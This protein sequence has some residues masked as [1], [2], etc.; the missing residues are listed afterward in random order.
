MCN[1]ARKHNRLLQVICLSLC[2]FA[3]SS[4]AT[5]EEVT[6]VPT[7]HELDSLLKVTTGDTIPVAIPRLISIH[8]NIIDWITTTPNVTVEIDLSRFQ[9]SRFSILLTGKYNP[10]IN[11]NTIQPRWVYNVSSVKVEFRKYWRTGNIEIASIPDTNKIEPDTTLWKPLA[12]LSYFQR[13]YISG[14]YVKYPRYWRA[15]YIGLYAAYNTFS[16]CLDGSGK[17][18]SAFSFGLSAG[19]SVPLYKHHDGSGWDL[20]LGLSVGAMITSYKKYKYVSEYGIFEYENTKPKHLLPYP[21]FQDIHI[22]LAYRFRTIEKKVLYGATRFHYKEYRREILERNRLVK[23]HAKAEREDSIM[24]YTDIYKTLSK[25]HE[26]LALYTDTTSYYYT[27]LNGAIGYTEK[28]IEDL[29]TDDKWK[30]MRDVLTH[31]LGY[32][33]KLANDLAPE[34]LRTD[35]EQREKDRIKAAKLQKQ[36]EKKNT[37]TAEKAAKEAQKEAK[38]AEK[39]ARK[40]AKKEVKTDNNP[41]ESSISGIDDVESTNNLETKKDE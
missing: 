38:K 39:E 14:R 34:H 21:M 1:D 25:A 41:T 15:Y 26:Q 30:F 28:N 20:D 4:Y 33:I 32:Y 29:K 8:T 22:S 16:I 5:A 37:K 23:I 31:N 2:L 18:G 12:K 3:T 9:R 19:F 36:E 10:Q 11:Y 17:Q 24:R 40:K 35:I 7:R 6:I 27:I 13:R